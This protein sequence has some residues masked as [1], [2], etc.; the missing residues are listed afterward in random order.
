MK[1]EINASMRLSKLLPGVIEEEALL[2]EFEQIV[3]YFDC[4]QEV[5][6]DGVEPMVQPTL[7]CLDD[8]RQDVKHDFA[9]RD[10]WMELAPESDGEFVLVPKVM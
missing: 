6:T 5:D 9:G 10:T 2:R 7:S 4:L 1:D 3:G 8:L